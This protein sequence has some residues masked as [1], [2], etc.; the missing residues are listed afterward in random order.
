MFNA[1]KLEQRGHEGPAKIVQQ[2]ASVG[3]RDNLALVVNL[4]GPSLQFGCRSVH[5]SPNPPGKLARFGNTKIRTKLGY[6]YIWH[7]S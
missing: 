5:F 3:V 1:W 7:G 4:L 6:Y 2:E